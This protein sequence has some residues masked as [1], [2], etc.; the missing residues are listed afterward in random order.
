MKY[1]LVAMAMPII[2]DRSVRRYLGA[3]GVVVDR[4]IRKAFRRE[5]KS[6]VARTPGLAKDNWLSS[7]LYLGCYLISIHKAAPGIITEERFERLIRALC[8]EI[9]RRQKESEEAFDEKNIIKRKT[10]AEQ[11][12]TSSYEMDWVSTFRRHSPD[13]YEFT[14]TKCGLCELGKREG[15]FHLIK[16]LCMSDYITFS[17]SGA[18]LVR[19]HTIA[20]GDGYCDFHVYRKERK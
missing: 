11:S 12:Q 4:K 3:D 16:Y 10:A 19:E 18:R 17:K 6:I 9:E 14:Y 20:N 5:Y 15:C 8:E 7:T 2:F 1:G 13:E